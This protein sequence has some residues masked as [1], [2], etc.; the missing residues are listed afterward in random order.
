MEP[1]IISMQR[2]SCIDKTSHDGLFR[3]R[4]RRRRYEEVLELEGVSIL[5][6]DFEPIKFY[7]LLF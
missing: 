1:A 7:N 3:L 2:S 5:I 6:E 4:E